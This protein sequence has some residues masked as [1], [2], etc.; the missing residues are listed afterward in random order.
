MKTASLSP[1]ARRG[2]EGSRF[3]SGRRKRSVPAKLQ[4]PLKFRGGQGGGFRRFRGKYGNG[5]V[6]VDIK[7]IIGKHTVKVPKGQAYAFGKAIGPQ[8]NGEGAAPVLHLNGEMGR[9][10]I[11]SFGPHEQGGARAQDLPVLNK[12]V[13]CTERRTA[14]P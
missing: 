1:S 11:K 9:Q 13:R 14:V 7:P 5:L 10:E 2:R 8:G 12:R 3:P 6:P 4:L